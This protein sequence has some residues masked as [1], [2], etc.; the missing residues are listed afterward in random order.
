[1]IS[2]RLGL[3]CFSS[4]PG[5]Q[6]RLADCGNRCCW[7]KIEKSRAEASQPERGQDALSANTKV[8]RVS[9]VREHETETDKPK[10]DRKNGTDFEK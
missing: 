10:K 6:R 1:M 7:S 3:A 8:D 4:S 9:E 2:V 5:T